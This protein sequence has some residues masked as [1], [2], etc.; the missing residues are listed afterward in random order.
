MKGPIYIRYR[1]EDGD[2]HRTL[3]RDAMHQELESLQALAKATGNY[4]PLHRWLENRAQE[5]FGLATATQ[6]KHEHAQAVKERTEA[7]RAAKDEHKRLKY[8]RIRALAVDSILTG[9]DLVGFIRV[10]WKDLYGEPLPSARTIY[11][12][13]KD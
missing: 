10:W 7:A 6:A 9:D 3:Y 4:E 1:F 11:R 12:A 8:E 5:G 2:E 13:L